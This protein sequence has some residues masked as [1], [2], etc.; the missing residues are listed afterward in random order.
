MPRLKAPPSPCSPDGS[1]GNW[2]SA[3]W[4]DDGIRRYIS[5][6]ECLAR[7]V[8]P[9]AGVSAQLGPEWTLLRIGRMDESMVCQERKAMGICAPGRSTRPCRK[10]RKPR[11][12]SSPSRTALF[13][14]AS[15]LNRGWAPAGHRWDRPSGRW[16]QWGSSQA[17]PDPG[18]MDSSPGAGRV[19]C[20]GR[21]CHDRG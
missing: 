6:C 17:V 4:P 3:R 19:R 20:T 9:A 16:E 12:S 8:Q 2:K 11:A 21:A 13:S 14:R 10:P 15:N 7:R 1:A 5:G 18:R